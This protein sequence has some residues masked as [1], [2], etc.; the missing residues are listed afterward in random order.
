MYAVWADSLASI[1][2]LI[3]AGAD[4]D[5]IDADGATAL[6]LAQWPDIVAFLEPLTG[7]SR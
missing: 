1:R 4:P 6:D 7:A 2:L 3:E 5:V